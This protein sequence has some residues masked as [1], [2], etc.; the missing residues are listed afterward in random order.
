MATSLTTR[1]APTPAD[2]NGTGYA[3]FTFQVRDDGGTANG[4]V[5][6]DAS[7]NTITFDVTPVN[8]V[9]VANPD[10]ATTT[11]DI[12]VTVDAAAN[13]TDVEDARPTVASIDAVTS[14]SATAPQVTLTSGAI[15]VVPPRDFSGPIV[16]D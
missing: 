11:E 6:T 9:P 2:A 15:V 12:P 10:Q 1:S 4:G 3:S 14:A 16:I 5:D 13:D 7:A 8:D